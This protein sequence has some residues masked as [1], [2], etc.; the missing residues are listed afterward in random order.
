MKQI[1]WVF[2]LRYFKAPKSTNAINVIAWISVLA[3]A[4]VTAALIVVFSVFNGFENLVKGLYNDFYA[5]VKITSATG[6][7]FLFSQ[8][9]QQKIKTNPAIVAYSGS[10]EEKALLVYN[11]NQTIA[12][13]KGV[14][15]QYNSITNLEGSKHIIQ[16]NY[17]LG[18]TS[19][20]LLCMGYTIVQQL[21]VDVTKSVYPVTIFLPSVNG[22]WQNAEEA[23]V[24]YNAVANSVF[25]VQQEFDSK[26]VFTNIGFMRYMLGLDSSTYSAIELK[27]SKNANTEKVVKQLQQ[28]LGNDWIVASRFQQ[29]K[30][31]FTTMQT[32]KWIIYFITCLILAVAAFNIVGA[33]SMLVLEKEKDIAVLQ[34]LGANTLFIRQI[35]M[36]EGMLL[37]FLGSFIGLVTGVII[38]GIQQIWHLIKLQGGSFIIDYYPVQMLLSDFVIIMLTIIA[39]VFIAAYFPAK[40]AAEKPFNLKS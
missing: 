18:N 34:S 35:F 23:L 37:A 27:L 11:N 14:D 21:G 33:L 38:C 15:N 9:L 40:K 10:V 28:M 19:N 1:T 26:Y 25:S 4:V 5:D 32:E 24:S 31:L 30:S 7:Q 3:I 17:A 16:G 29:N 13:V 2:A 22:Q 36:A 39:I 12:V 6:K 20:P 8:S